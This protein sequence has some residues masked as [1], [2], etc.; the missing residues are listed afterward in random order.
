MQS[1]S[2][3]PTVAKENKNIKVTELAKSSPEAWIQ[4]SGITLHPLYITPPADAASFA[5]YD[6]ALLLEGKFDSAFDEAPA[7][8][9]TTASSGEQEASDD[10]ELPET[11]DLHSYSS[12]Y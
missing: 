6:L 4:E 3:D 2:L 10:A 1:G 5:Q 8:S 7:A 11:G 9:K 12:R